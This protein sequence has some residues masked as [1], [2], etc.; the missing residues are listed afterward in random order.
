MKTNDVPSPRAI[1][2]GP[3]HKTACHFAEELVGRRSKFSEPVGAGDG[4]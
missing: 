1:D 3:D 4:S 2:G